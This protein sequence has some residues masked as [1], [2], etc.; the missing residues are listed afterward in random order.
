MK[1]I[2]SLCV[3][4][5]CGTITLKAAD[6][7]RRPQGDGKP[8]QG[9]S[10]HFPVAISPDMIFKMLDTDKNA[11][12]SKDEFMAGPIARE[13]PDK[14][15]ERFKALDKNGDGKI[16]VAEFRAGHALDKKKP[17]AGN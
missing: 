7:P 8:G 12:L 10:G 3:L 16:S 11:Y 1:T 17:A 2:L 5:L 6:G 15:G 9:P 14:A 4:A 13:H